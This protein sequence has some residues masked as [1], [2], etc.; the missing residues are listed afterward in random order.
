MSDET[1]RK[2]LASHLNLMT[3]IS[4]DDVFGDADTRYRPLHLPEDNATMFAGYIGRDYTPLFWAIIV[5]SSVPSCSFLN[6]SCSL[7]ILW[8]Q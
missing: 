3:R 8:Q 1:F 4:R 7:P 6:C 2:S 5:P